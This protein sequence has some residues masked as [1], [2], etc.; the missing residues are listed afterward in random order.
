MPGGYYIAV[1]GMRSRLD[2]LDRSPL[3]ARVGTA[4]RALV[5]VAAPPRH[6]RFDIRIQA[7][8]LRYGR[9]IVH[10]PVL[11]KLPAG[12]APPLGARLE[13]LGVLTEPRGRSL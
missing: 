11:L 9:Q 1:T 7:L 4:E 3:S 2:A 6:G 12:R 10:E 5:V 8:L 13:A